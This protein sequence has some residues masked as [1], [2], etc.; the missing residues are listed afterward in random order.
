VLVAK[1]GCLMQGANLK[2]PRCQVVRIPEEVNTG[3]EGSLNHRE[4][5]IVTRAKGELHLIATPLNLLACQ[6]SCR[7]LNRYTGKNPGRS[8]YFQ[9]VH[10]MHDIV[11]ACVMGIAVQCCNARCA[12][13]AQLRGS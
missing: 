3:M 6:V 13:G 10:Q 1:F 12:D 11:Y 8:A 4:V 5:V 9:E 2:G 7:I